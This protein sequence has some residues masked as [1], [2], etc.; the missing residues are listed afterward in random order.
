MRWFLIRY[1]H[2]S[3][4]RYKEYFKT[5]KKGG[6]KNL[7]SSKVRYKVF[8]FF[9]PP[10]FYLDL[11]SSKVRY[12]ASTIKHCRSS[13]YCIYIPPRLDIKYLHKIYLFLLNLYLHSSKVRYKVMPL[14]VIIWIVPHLHS[15][16]VRYKDQIAQAIKDKRIF[17][18]LQ[19]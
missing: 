14:G 12:K 17:T 16:K 15:S 1:L 11:H 10:S 4:V 18:F 13:S 9:N 8:H 6:V 7:H 3:K 19:G 5:T 2:S